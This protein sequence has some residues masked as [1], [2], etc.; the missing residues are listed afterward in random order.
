MGTMIITSLMHD[1]F[2]VLY[3]S[4]IDSYLKDCYSESVLSFTSSLER[5][6]EY[7]VKVS[8]LA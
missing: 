3:I 8:L 7:F 2:D 4:A 6:Y 1:L 5:L